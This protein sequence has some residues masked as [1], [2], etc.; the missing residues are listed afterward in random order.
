MLTGGYIYMIE[1]DV[2]I[3]YLY[4]LIIQKTGVFQSRFSDDT[5]LYR[6]KK[7]MKMEEQMKRRMRGFLLRKR[8][9]RFS[10]VLTL[11]FL[12]GAALM[13]SG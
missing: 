8:T 13:I 1:I 3:F 12:L 9:M 6:G 4:T 10:A 2:L 7:G 11:C 5:M